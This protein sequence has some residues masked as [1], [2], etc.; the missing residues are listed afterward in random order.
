M[1]IKGEGFR[2]PETD[3]G[4]VL[5]IV[6]DYLHVQ[7]PFAGGVYT[8]DEI[9]D[10]CPVKRED[11]AREDSNMVAAVVLNGAGIAIKE[12]HLDYFQRVVE[13]RGEEVKV[14]VRPQ[15]EAEESYQTKPDMSGRK[16][17]AI[18]SASAQEA[19]KTKTNVSL[20]GVSFATELQNR[21]DPKDGWSEQIEL[22]HISRQAEPG[23]QEEADPDPVPEVVVR[24]RQVP[25]EVVSRTEPSKEQVIVHLKNI[26][27]P[28]KVVGH[29]SPVR[30]PE[31]IVP[32]ESIQTSED[33]VE[34]RQVQPSYIEPLPVEVSDESI[35]PISFIDGE[36]PL[37]REPVV[38]LEPVYNT[39]SY[40]FEDFHQP[41]IETLTLE[42]LLP[43]EEIFVAPENLTLTEQIIL[44]AEESE[45]INDEIQEEI[46]VLAAEIDRE[47]QGLVEMIAD[48]AIGAEEIGLVE[49]K[50]EI[51]CAT[52]LEYAGIEYDQEIL[53]RFV[54]TLIRQEIEKNRPETEAAITD[55]GTHE[56]KTFT[57]RDF[58]LAIQSRLMDF[59]RI[60]RYAITNHGEVKVWGA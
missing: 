6:G 56:A 11:M 55:R 13:A 26:P 48:P 38:E 46:K 49:Q 40:I 27:R 29:H 37:T 4:P 16:E 17:S 33:Q 15:E 51:L 19:A 41:E 8:L 53:Q 5:D 54:Q 25:T 52:L 18:R 50:L 12:E 59:R 47:V 31:D 36:D 30:Q 35:V 20:A 57:L 7:L 9:L 34:T 1:K 10:M 42:D 32:S 45:T 22:E 14:T 28:D 24:K 58:V 3:N 44:Y 43:A 23:Y 39:A 2:P 21:T 60:G